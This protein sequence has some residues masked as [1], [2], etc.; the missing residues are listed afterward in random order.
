M[1]DFDAL[2][3]NIKKGKI[4]N[5]Y[6]FCGL[7]EELIKEGISL[8][9]KKTIDESLI[10]LNYIRLDGTN[11]SFDDILNA[12]ET[13]P[14]M[15]DRKLVVVYRAAFLKDKT[16]S[17]LTK[18][19]N[20]IN[21]YLKDIPSYTTLIIYTLFNDKRESPKKNNKLKALD[22]VSEV[23]YCDRLK[24]DRYYKKVEEV[25]KERGKE[26][27]K[28]E[29]RYFAERVQNNFDI[30]KREAD[31]I[32]AYTEGR[33]IKRQDI[34]KLV[35]TS[36]EDDIFDLIDLISTRKV[37]KAMD[38]LDG[39]LFK[40]DQHMLIITNVEN[41]FKRLYEI[42]ILVE[43]GYNVND[44][45]TKYRLPVFVCEKLVGQCNKFTKKQLQK[46]MEICLETDVKLKTTSNDKTIEL[47]LML[48][49]IFMIK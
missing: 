10:D 19:Y 45:A 43:K 34:D 29:A 33:E 39:L 8:I 26:I 15:G 1:I 12:S 24:K 48:F 32:I 46:I 18:L 6:I 47:E 17:S 5:S 37:E 9:A 7:D 16:D 4:K 21:E 36:S 28:I 44:L 35:A 30:I 27:N 41:N 25:F 31:K 42:K 20:E 22:K 40:S 3:E 2:E 49:K 13:M 23:V 38:L 11:V 14:F